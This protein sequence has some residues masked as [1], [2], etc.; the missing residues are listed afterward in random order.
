VVAVERSAILADAG[1]ASAD[2]MAELLGR[3]LEVARPAKVAGVGVVVRAAMRQR[4]DVV[5]HRCDHGA[6]RS[7]AT[8]AQAIGALEPTQAL[9]LTGA[10]A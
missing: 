5:D 9:R 4:L 8:L 10:A 2:L 1:P 6:A 7:Q 3:R